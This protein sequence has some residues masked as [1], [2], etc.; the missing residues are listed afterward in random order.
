M[1]VPPHAQSI[2]YVPLIY[3]ERYIGGAVL[4]SAQTNYY[5]PEKARLAMA[6]ANSIVA[7]LNNAYAHDQALRAAK[8]GERSRLARELHDS[9]AQLL[10]GVVLGTRTMLEKYGAISE[11][12]ENTLRYVLKLAESGQGDL[13][14]LIH[15]LRSDA[16]EQNGL[17]AS[18][19]SHLNELCARHNLQFESSLSTAEPTISIQVKQAL[20][21]M[22]IEAVQNTVKHAAASLVKL[23]FGIVQDSYELTISD[24]GRGFDTS[25]TFIG[26][27]GLSTMRER[28]EA[29]GGHYTITSQPGNGTTVRATVPIKLV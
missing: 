26:H 8:Q 16:L 6:F 21:R 28:I 3:R 25:Q 15:E 1:V 2:M 12:L 7:A 18:L 13:R 29:F 27:Y 19:I 22:S 20:L 11:D 9:I 17:L 24:N 4:D 23:T 5:T 14:V 10:F